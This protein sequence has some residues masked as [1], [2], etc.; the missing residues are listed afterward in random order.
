M[1][2]I[3]REQA[4]TYK[5][6]TRINVLVCPHAVYTTTP[7]LLE[8][9]LQLSEELKLPLHLHLAE[10]ATETAQC[11]EQWGKRPIPYCHDLGLLRSGTSLAH[12][13]NVSEQELDTLADNNVSVAHNPSSNMKLPS[14]ISPVPAMGQ[15]GI[16]V[17]LG[18]D[19][20]ASNNRLNMFTEM[21]RAALLHKVQNDDPTSMPAQDVLDMAT[22]HGG[23]IYSGQV[24]DAR[25]LGILAPGHA[26]DMIALDMTAH[27]LQPMYAPPSHLVYAATGMEVHFS[28]VEGEVLYRDGKYSR[29]DYAVLL[30]EIT[31]IRQWTLK[32]SQK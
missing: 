3:V 4:H 8:Q 11:L 20:A 12:V 30:E 23:R 16:C 28:M 25:H 22:R 27:N 13:V 10:T 2:D 26:A 1:L 29:F 32:A 21:G 15:R 6:D 7:Q 31:K 24:N 9:C 18:T 14:G 19:G 5:D 17:G